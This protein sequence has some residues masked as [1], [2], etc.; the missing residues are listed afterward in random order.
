MEKGT[1]DRRK[2]QGWGQVTGRGDSSRDERQGEKA[3]KLNEKH[4]KDQISTG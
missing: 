4:K 1:S 3:R 2:R